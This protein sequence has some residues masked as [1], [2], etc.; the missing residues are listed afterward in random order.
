MDQAAAGD[1]KAEDERRAKLQQHL[2]AALH[3]DL[4]SASP[5]GSITSA[6]ANHEGSLAEDITVQESSD[7]DAAEDSAYWDLVRHRIPPYIE[8]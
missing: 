7:T 4:L 6:S 3:T 2:A 8:N 1:A 5:T